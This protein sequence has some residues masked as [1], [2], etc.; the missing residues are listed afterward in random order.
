MVN[1]NLNFYFCRL[2]VSDDNIIFIMKKLFFRGMM[3]VATLLAIISCSEEVERSEIGYLPFK[4][5]ENGKWG[6]IGTDGTVLFEDEFKDE[7]TVAMNNRFLVK[8]GNGL[9]EIY[10]AEA[11]PEKIGEEYLQ[12]ADYTA[13]VTPSV[14]K[15][16]KICLIDVNGNV[17]ATLDKANSKNIVKCSKF[18]YGYASIVTEDDKWGI[19]NT[20]GDIVIEPKYDY[21]IPLSSSNFFAGIENHKKN[22]NE[23]NIVKVLDTSGKAICEVKC[24]K[25]QKYNYISDDYS[26]AN[27][28]AVCVSVDGEDQYGFIDFQKN[29]VVKPSSKIKR[30]SETKGDKF[31]F[32]NG[33]NEGVMNF[34]GEVVLRA[35]YDGLYWA[36]DDMLIA[37]DSED[38]RYSLINLEGDKIT[39]EKYLKILPFYLFDGE[40]APVQ[41]DDNSW[42]FIDKKGEEVKLKNAPDI[43]R[44]G[45]DNAN[46]MVESDF[47]DIDA[48]TSRLKLDKNGLMGFS[49]DMTPQQIVKAY[50][51]VDGNKNG[52]LDATP[53]ENLCCVNTS[54]SSRGLEI[55]SWVNYHYEHCMSDYIDGKFVWTKAL[56]TE[57]SVYVKGH[58]LDG[59]IDLLYNKVAAIVKS[60]GK[61]VK[62]NS[63][64]AIVKISE[65]RGWVILNEESQLIITIYNSSEYQDYGIDSYA[66][67]GE[68]TKEYIK[69]SGN[70]LVEEPVAEDTV[71]YV[72]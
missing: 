32:S 1:L 62:E 37:Y 4:T 42:G 52:K 27:Y 47:V 50:N 29:V 13:S 69:P 3:I 40:Y 26:N 8:N 45:M 10:T 22:E 33:E 53:K 19:I 71:D 36:N 16:E 39:K 24:G 63:G 41:I 12:I 21:V 56:P 7:P 48:I 49:L 6:M 31:I 14:K 44:F 25:G 64:A 23:A 66:K 2:E 67:D 28:L 20:K 61:V 9:W 58:M 46:D 70:R 55:E 5:S 72:Y 11:K 65:N 17:K 18:L 59:K 68:T 51:E 54:Y 30:I 38:N 57:I 35:K 15:N 60:Q 43:Y 34:S